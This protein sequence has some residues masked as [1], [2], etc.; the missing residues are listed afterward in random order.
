MPLNFKERI[1]FFNPPSFDAAIRM[2]THCYEQC[3][4]KSEAHSYWKEKIKGNFDQKNNG[5]RSLEDISTQN[6]PPKKN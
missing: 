2:A 1:E 3:K 6:G 4:E 5:F